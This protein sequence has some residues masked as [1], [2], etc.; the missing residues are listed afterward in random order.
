[1]V[2]K[3]KKRSKVEKIKFNWKTVI[4]II[5]ALIVIILLF[6]LIGKAGLQ[7]SK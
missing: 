2:K 5:G 4:V 3:I 7:M 6:M 1:M